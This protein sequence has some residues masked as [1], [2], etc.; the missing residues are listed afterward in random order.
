MAAVESSLVDLAGVSLE[1]L[2]SID[3]RILAASVRE[4]LPEIDRQLASVSTI[5]GGSMRRE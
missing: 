2:R 4:L 5:D 3:D 1:T